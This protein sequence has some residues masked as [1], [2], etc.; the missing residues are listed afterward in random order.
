[1]SATFFAQLLVNGIMLGLIYAL[2]AVGLS[3]IFGV[4]EVVN[5]AHGQIYTLGAFAMLFMVSGLGLG[6]VPAV[7]GATI[8]VALAGYLLYEGFLRFL[9]QGEFERGIILT[10]GL[11]MIIQNGMLYL[12]GATPRVVD[13]EFSFVTISA[14]GVSL[15]L[16]RG[17]AGLFAVVAIGGLHLL[18]TRTRFGKAMRAMAQNAEAAFVVGM[19]PRVVASHAVIIGLAL[20]GLAGAILAPVFTVHPL[21]GI[22]ILFKAFAIVII[23]GLGHIPGTAVAAL[24]I[25]VCESFAGGIGSAALQDA[26]VFLLMIAILQ[27]RPL[28]LFGKGVRI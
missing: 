24:I 10:L 12:F 11:G 18:L 9:K 27:W 6:Y 22:P 26:T 13:T 14:A 23:G 25:G 17:L 1:M 21:I 16:S 20:T 2:I 19:R 3:L 15:D 28:G 7:L 8:L 5:F 4:L